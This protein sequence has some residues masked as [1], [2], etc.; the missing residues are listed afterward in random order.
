MSFWG[1]RRNNYHLYEIFTL[2]HRFNDATGK[3]IVFSF[4]IRAQ[5]RQK[6]PGMLI[7]LFDFKK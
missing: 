1:N 3:K 5:S 2:N 6:N 7:G 4:R